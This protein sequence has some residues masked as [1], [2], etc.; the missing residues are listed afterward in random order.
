MTARQIRSWLLQQPR[1]A[2]VRVTPADGGEPEVIKLTKRS[3]MARLSETIEALGPELLEMLDKDNNLIRASRDSQDSHRSD[4][5]EIPAA[6]AADPQALQVTHFA[7]LIHRAYE[8][9]TEIAFNK[10]VDYELGEVTA[11]ATYYLAEIYTHFSKALMASERPVLELFKL[12]SR[13]ILPTSA[14]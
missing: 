13:A 7:N 3:N 11:A 5:A 6:I 14:S 8:H 2:V 4:A 10:L 12:F 9:S 1:G